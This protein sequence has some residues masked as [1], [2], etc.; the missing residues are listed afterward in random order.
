MMQ[1]L[2]ICLCLLT[3]SGWAKT[4]QEIGRDQLLSIVGGEWIASSL[5]VANELEVA[6]LLQS[7]PKSADE[8]ALAVHA[9]KD[10]V[11]R[12]LR[13]LASVGIFEEMQEGV[14]SNN[15]ASQLLVK[16]N[17]FTLH[18]TIR[19][20]GQFV[21]PVFDD[22]LPSVQT[23]VTAFEIKNKEAVFPYLK[24]HPAQAHL[25]HAAMREK[26]KAVIASSLA[27]YDF[28][29]YKTLYDIGGGQG[30]F[31]LALLNQ[32]PHMQG[33]LFDLPEVIAKNSAQNPRLALV[34]GDFFQSIPKG[35]EAYLL[36]SVLH[37][38]DD[39]KAAAILKNC[40]TAMDKGSHLILV[41]YV[42]MPK[43]ELY[44][45]C[46]DVL[47]LAMVGGKER[48]LSAYEVLLTQAGFKLKKVYPTQTEFSIL[49]AEKF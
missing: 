43:G 39:E 15:E 23:G 6:D 10:S 2:L 34:S 26:S 28:S 49:V 5:Y 36:K 38:W 12:I 19:F 46:M 37:D 29:P 33:T 41:E 22:L 40:H 17:P 18:D 30:H 9:E 35:G 11:N 13:L 42:L 7:G 4:P 21:H 3:V 20:Y 8:I 32:Y 1:K 44:A 24:S 31:M 48:T 16:N 47:M 27:S 25:F 14:Y 45:K